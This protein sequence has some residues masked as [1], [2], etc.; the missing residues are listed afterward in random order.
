MGEPF[1]KEELY[2][3]EDARCK[4][5]I[6]VSIQYQNVDTNPISNFFNILRQLLSGYASNSLTAEKQVC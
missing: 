2:V 6:G 4:V 5:C 1:G 3:G